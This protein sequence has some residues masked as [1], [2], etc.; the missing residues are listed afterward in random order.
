MRGATLRW[1]GVVPSYS[2]PCAS[3]DNPFS[4]ALFRTLKYQV[5]IP[6]KSFA[7]RDSA[8]E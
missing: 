7:T 6:Y 1:L 2:R 5:H 4:E 8:R 3:N